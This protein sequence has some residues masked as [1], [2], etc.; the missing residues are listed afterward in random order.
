MKTDVDRWWDTYNAALAGYTGLLTLRPG[1]AVTGFVDNLHTL[2]KMSADKAHGSL[3]ALRKL[4]AAQA[5]PMNEQI[6][7][8]GGRK[9]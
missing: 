5:L 6:G 9:P 8:Y 3:L 1:D 4:Q 7:A 2:A